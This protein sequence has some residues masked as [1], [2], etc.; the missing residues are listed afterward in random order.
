LKS[1]KPYL[2]PIIIGICSFLSIVDNLDISNIPKFAVSVLGIISIVLLLFKH[3]YSGLLIK[4]W[5]CSQF[6]YIVYETSE[7]M[8][9]GVL[10]SQRT[11]YWNTSQI[12]NFSFGLTINSLVIKGNLVP[13]FYM[14]L[15][16]IDS[17][18]I[19][20][21][22][23]KSITINSGLE[24]ENKLGDVFP[25][26]GIFV[27]SLLMDDKSLWLI[28]KLD[29]PFIFKENSFDY[30]LLHPHEGKDFKLKGRQL[31]YLRLLNDDKEMNKMTNLLNEYPLIDY[32]EVEM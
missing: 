3:K 2:L 24:R 13:L 27:K 4:I 12:F 28:A 32:V 6:P 20:A 25:L 26:N 9:N 18:K 11:N 31:A 5:I 21:H 29:H 22:I 1:L 10:F 8:E 30:V 15:Y 14:W 17:I 16:D 19:S 23:G 7:M